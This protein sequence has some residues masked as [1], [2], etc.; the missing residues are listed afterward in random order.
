MYKQLRWIV[1]T[2]FLIP[3]LLIVSAIPSFAEGKNNEEGKVIFRYKTDFEGISR[4]LGVTEEEYFELR[5]QKSI[6]EIAK[7]RGISED[8]VFRYFIEKRFDALKKSY[9]KGDFDIGFVMD[10]CLRLKDDIEWEI[11][12]KKGKDG[13]ITTE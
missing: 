10:Y 8:E 4:F 5:N 9:E 13:K 3:L 7:E 1:I 2:F 6:V 12:V 11:N